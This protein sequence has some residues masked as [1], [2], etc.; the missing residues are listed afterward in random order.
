MKIRCKHC[1]EFFYPDDETQELLFSGYI[2]S[3]SVKTC[4]DCWYLLEHSQKD[5]SEM[6]S[7][8]DMGL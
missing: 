5:M 4:N 1:G 6:I 3:Y 2:E 8:A 7:D